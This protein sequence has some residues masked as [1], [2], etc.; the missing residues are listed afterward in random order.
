[1][2]TVTRSVV[3]STSVSVS[4]A[5]ADN[6]ASAGVD[7]TST[8]GTLTFGPTVVTQTI[9]VPILGDTIPEDSDAFF[10][11]LF[12]PSAGA[13]IAVGQGVGAILNDDGNALLRTAPV[14]VVLADPTLFRSGDLTGTV[15]GTHYGEQ[16][17]QT[18]VNIVDP[19]HPM[20]AGLSGS[21]T[22]VS[23]AEAFNWGVAGSAA[24]KVATLTGDAGKA[25]IFGYEVGKPM[26]GGSSAPDRRVGLYLGL[27]SGTALTAAGGA[28][29]DAAIL[30]AASSDPDADGLTTIEEYRSGTDP[31]NADTNGDGIPDKSQIA[32]GSATNLDVDLDGVLNTAEVQNGTDPFRADSDGDGVNDLQDCFALD[33]IRWQCPSPQPGD[34]TPPLIN[35]QFPL[36]ATL[37]SVVPPLP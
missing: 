6:T 34:V 35:L 7:Y 19:S 29:F 26:A 36:N 1:M 5:T 17:N 22:V 8:S 20:A 37:V 18:Q 11:N 13:S 3:T 12:S 25:T 23:S 21:Q 32:A 4:Y 30:W 31:R 2:F 24:A 15:S 33:P 10:V 14:P 27:S 16:L 9:S 28:L